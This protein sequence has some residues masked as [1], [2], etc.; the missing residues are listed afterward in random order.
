MKNKQL[1]PFITVAAV[2][3]AAF[4]MAVNYKTFVLTGGL[5]PGGVA[6]LSLLLIRLIK[7]TAGFELPFSVVNIALNAG[8]VY[9]GFKYLGKRFT[10]FSCL[11]IIENGIFTDL[12]PA[13]TMT[14]DILL[15]TIF[16]GI[17][18]G[19]AISIC[20]NYGATSGGTDFI[21]IFLSEKRGIDSFSI[22]LAFNAV[23][24]SI[25]GLN[26]GW[27]K[28]LYS[29]IFQY[30]TTSVIHLLF[31]KYRQSTFFIVTETPDEVCK[32]I[33]SVSGH[34]ATILKGEGSYEH[35]ERNVVYSVVSSAQSKRVINAVHEVDPE[36]F[37]NEVK[38][39]KLKGNFYL[40]KEE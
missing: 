34:G 32:A 36:A 28:A 24:I 11:L 37:I 9:I 19:A 39:E 5:Y 23:V 18:D 2:T 4:I 27:D 33:D 40:P 15:I 29:I 14:E 22:I 31:K 25:A 6:S 3:V 8:P 30:V 12:I 21:S 35:S 7:S 10:L 26:F 38:T 13:Y 17:I 16:G 20:L 1:N